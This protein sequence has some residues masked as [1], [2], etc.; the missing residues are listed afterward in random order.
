MGGASEASEHDSAVCM[1]EDTILVT[2][3]HVRIDRMRSH[4][5]TAMGVQNSTHIFTTNSEMTLE[6]AQPP[7]LSNLSE[8]HRLYYCVATQETRNKH[9]PNSSDPFYLNT[10]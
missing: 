3:R 5:P 4:M 6:V 8:Q 2:P 9:A 7:L 1:I 10:T